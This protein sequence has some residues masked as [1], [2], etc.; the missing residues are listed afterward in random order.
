MT[1]NEA[2]IKAAFLY[3]FAR[4]VTWPETAFGADD[5]PFVVAVLGEDPLGA[6]LD[7][8]FEGKSVGDRAFVV[9]R[10]KA[11]AELGV[12]QLLY[13]RDT[14]QLAKA[15]DALRD[16]AVLVVGDG[17]GVTGAGGTIAFYQEQTPE[18]VKVRFEANPDVA[19]R[20]GLTI[21]S[22]LLALARVVRDKPGGD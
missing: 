1:A 3:N 8:A 20:A 22:K 11:A 13:L 21:S 9:K 2:S 17:D 15:L 16:R 18:G 12:C 14:S 6:A 10:V 5:A 19:G 4:L 7:K